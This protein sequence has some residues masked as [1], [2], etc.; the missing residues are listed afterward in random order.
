MHA[1]DAVILSVCLLSNLCHT[2]YWGLRKNS[3]KTFEQLALKKTKQNKTKT[4]KTVQKPFTHLLYI[5]T[6]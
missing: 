6:I 5:A 4:K 2:I 3:S 1:D